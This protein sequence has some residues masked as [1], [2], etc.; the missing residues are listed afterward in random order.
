MQDDKPLPFSVLKVLTDRNEDTCLYDGTMKSRM[1]D[2]HLP[3][4]DCVNGNDTNISVEGWN[5]FCT[6]DQMVMMASMSAGSKEKCGCVYQQC[7]LTS[8]ES[9]GN[10]DICHYRCVTSTRPNEFRLQIHSGIHRGGGICE[11]IPKVFSDGI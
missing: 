10:M 8:K 9:N 1:L 3:R 7:P 6:E 11:I 4:P 5:L 2:I